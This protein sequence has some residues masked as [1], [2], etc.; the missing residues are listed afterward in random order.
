MNTRRDDGRLT[1]FLCG[2]VMLGRGIDQI[3]PHPLDPTLRESYCHDARDYVALAE[4]AN[5]PIPRA[6]DYSW[7][8]GDALDVLAA[9]AP[10][11]RIMNLET[12]VTR[13]DQFAPR[14]AVHYRMSPANLPGLTV[15]R[16]D[17]CAL[18]NNHV[19]D[20]GRPG[21]QET[22]DTL[23]GAGLQVAGA[24]LNTRQAQRPATVTAERGRILVFAF[25]TP[26]SGVPAHWA[27]TGDRGGIDV[28]PELSRNGAA[29]LADRIHRHKRPGDIVVV[30][31]HWGSNWGYDIPE[32]QIRLAHQL[33][34]N[35][36]DIVHGHSSHHPRPIEVYRNR[37]ILYG[38][39]DLINDYEGIGVH[40][41]YRDD[42][43]LLYL[44]SI[45]PTGE[46][47]CLRVAPMQARRMR[48]HRASPE[49]T[50]WTRTVLG[51]V[52]SRSGIRIDV[53]PNR[54]LTLRP[55]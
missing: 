40:Q 22:L 30:S 13:S 33:I 41:Q 50:E 2:D 20:F 3:L 48:L 37:L 27:A 34:D 55:N 53:T 39:G 26:S 35:G 9:A 16:P 19:L 6:A 54:M 45:A 51:S 7:P 28:L 21:L 24:G 25:G 47:A 46:L 38:C 36:A 12:S 42:L 49:D 4:A 17:V 14:K 31:V 5:G 11:A 10:D 15:A 8:W 18:A 1:L 29:R 52:S 32:E 44:P 23:T 43:R